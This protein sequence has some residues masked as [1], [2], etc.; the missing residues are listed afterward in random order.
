VSNKKSVA[1]PP[2]SHDRTPI[3]ETDSPQPLDECAP[4]TTL[5]LPAPTF[6]FSLRPYLLL[7]ILTLL[8]LLPFSSEAFHADDPL[9]LWT[10][11]HIVQRP[12]DPFGF[13]VAWALSDAPMWKITKNPPLASYYAALAGSLAGWSEKAQHLAFLLPALTV[14]LGTYRLAQRFTRLP[15]IAALA[16]LLTPGF[17]VSSTSVMCDTTMLALWIL[18][19]IFWL[20][21]LEPI[22]PSVLIIS[23]LLA[24]ACALTKYF[25]LALI[26]LLFAYSLE[27]CRRI[28]P[29]ARYLLIPSFIFAGYECWTRA[30]YGAGLL[31]EAARYALDH[32]PGSALA[33]TLITLA[34]A[35]GCAIT[36]LILAPLIWRWEWILAAGTVGGLV[37]WTTASG[38]IRLP[39]L[40]G[41]HDHWEWISCQMALLVVGGLFILAIALAQWRQRKDANS[42]LLALWVLGTFLFAAFVNWTINARSILPLVPAAAI[43]SARGLQTVDSSKRSIIKI[44]VALILAGVVSLWVT[45]GDAELANSARTAAALIHAETGSGSGRRLFQGHWG[46]QYYMQ[47]FGF[48]PYDARTY[49]VRSEDLI[50]IPE[51]NTDLVALPQSVVI[52][53]RTIEQRM[54]CGASTMSG[55]SGAGFYFAGWGPLPFAFGPVPAERY[56]LLELAPV[57]HR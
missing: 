40:P 3:S 44:T 18:A 50:V 46:F 52:S 45:C 7:T 16:T 27:R 2:R 23:G 9:S 14:I 17:L 4:K 5:A 54:R 20:E 22:K 31:T 49:Q 37:A 39:A 25:G 11:Q 26:P 19:I 36:A 53:R 33:D 55:P 30:R 43:L 29:W 51:N 24:G 41:A 6:W 47:E 1:V 57:E 32:Q 15:L 21:G 28:E 42:F 48:I 13:Q 38:W 12:F 10:A 34:F 35:G 56:F 8:C